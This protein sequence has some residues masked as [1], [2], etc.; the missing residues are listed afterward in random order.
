MIYCPFQITSRIG[1][2]PF[3]ILDFAESVNIRM[4]FEGIR[5]MSNK[6]EESKF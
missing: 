4:E 5:F 3:G 2:L 6:L 1:G